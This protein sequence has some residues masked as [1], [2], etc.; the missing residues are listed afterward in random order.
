M[1][2]GASIAAGAATGMGIAALTGNDVL[3]GGVTGGLGG[4]GGGNM[5]AAFNP[6]TATVPAGTLLW[7]MRQC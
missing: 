4:Y 5:A 7:Q 2:I 1:G 3:M 6:A